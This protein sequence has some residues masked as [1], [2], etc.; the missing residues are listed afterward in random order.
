[1][2]ED[3]LI[4]SD[5][6]AAPAEVH[7]SP[8][9]VL[10]IDDE[11]EVHKVTKLA[12]K[13]FSFDGR[14]LAFLS[15]YS[16][17]EAR[18]LLKSTPE[19]AVILL[20]VVMETESA[21]LDLV[22]FI[23]RDL[24]NHTSRIVLRTGQP[25]QAPEREVVREYDINDYKAKTELTSQK[26]FTL[27]HASLRSYR[28]IVTLEK[29]KQ[30]LEKVIRASKG[31]FEKRAFQGFVEGAMEQLLLLLRLDGSSI[32]TYDSLALQLQDAQLKVLAAS[33][34][35][36]MGVET[37]K[38]SQLPDR[39]QSI[40]REAVESRSNVFRNGCLVIYCANERLTTLFF[41][42]GVHNLSEMDRNL[43]NLFTENIV[44]ALENIRLNEVLRES[45][46]E[47][48]YRL[49]EVIETRSEETGYHVKRV[50]L[51]AELI[52]NLAG[53][54]P[55]Q[56]DVLKQASPLHDIGKVGIPD[57]V[58]NNPGK[59]APDEWEVMKTHARLGHEILRGSGNPLLDAAAIIALTHHE[60]WDGSGYPAGHRGEDIHIFGRITALADV[61]DALGSWRCY[62]EPWP[63]E[64]I[65]ALLG[66]QAGR[67]FD[68]HLVGL[69]LE[70][71]AQFFAIR[72]RYRDEAPH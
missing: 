7:R 19:V 21:G 44:V 16:A 28:D 36:E 13:R 64:R 15:A 10:I 14:P 69:L 43:L 2:M 24:Q 11:S 33:H 42:E 40:V 23:R 60:R 34:G 26:L 59:L 5:E 1:M 6:V 25:G 71:Q 4:F 57:T 62:K 49:G 61:F 50:A 8:W 31:I 55:E 51:Y 17:R 72:D 32:Y 58:L 41:V 18:A 54:P 37:L 12:L 48:I 67:H 70:N 30:G 9:R 38:V 46:K 52:G 39:M 20:D 66:E 47:I 22:R 27:M 63:D 29:S 53:L 68:P 35:N 56:V 3:E 65:L 45:K